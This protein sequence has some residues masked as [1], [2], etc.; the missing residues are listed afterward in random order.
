MILHVTQGE[1]GVIFESNRPNY[2]FLATF[3][4]SPCIILTVWA[5]TGLQKRA[6]VVHMH[7][8]NDPADLAKKLGDIFGEMG[9]FDELEVRI[10]TETSTQ[11]EEAQTRTL[12][13]VRL[14]VSK[15]L[16][17]SNVRTVTRNSAVLL[18]AQ[19][20]ALMYLDDEDIVQAGGLVLLQ[21]AMQ[22]DEVFQKASGATVPLLIRT[23]L[24]EEQHQAMLKDIGI[25][26]KQKKFF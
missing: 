7:E 4:A 12:F 8:K 23:S 22:H 5:R 6:A 25:L 13:G 3:G 16:G 26:G 24:K 21:D 9:S 15:S 11:H 18:S 2:Q 20:G 1:I 10:V 17:L 19:S 14:A